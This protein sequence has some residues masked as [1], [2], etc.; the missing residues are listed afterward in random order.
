MKSKRGELIWDEL[1]PWIITAGFII[2]A[3]ILSF[4]LSGHGKNLIE[5]IKNLFRFGK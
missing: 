2:L 4:Y 1:I 3:M 5:Y